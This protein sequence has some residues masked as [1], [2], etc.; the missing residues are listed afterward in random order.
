MT[1]SFTLDGV[2]FVPQQFDFVNSFNNLQKV[3]WIQADPFHQFDNIIVDEAVSGPT[4]GSILIPSGSTKTLILGE[5][6]DSTGAYFV[7]GTLTLTNKMCNVRS[8]NSIGVFA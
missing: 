8:G 3:E 5:T 6:I 1:Q 7:E 4:P 2:S